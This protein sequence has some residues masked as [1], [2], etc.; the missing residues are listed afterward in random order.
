V[1]RV[2]FSLDKKIRLLNMTYGNQ[3]RISINI[4]NLSK[5]IGRRGES[6]VKRIYNKDYKKARKKR[7][8]DKN[9][10]LAI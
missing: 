8:R 6:Q 2:S 3:R 4:K 1:I 7:V 5:N 10:N 9:D